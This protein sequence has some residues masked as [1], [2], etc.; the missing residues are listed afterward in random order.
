[1]NKKTLLNTTGLALFIPLAF[2]QCKKELSPPSAQQS[3]KQ[4]WIKDYFKELSS[5]NYPNIYAVSW[6]Q[7][8]FD[9]SFLS[10]NSSEAALQQY[11][12][13]VSNS[14]FLEQCLFVNGKLTFQAN[15]IYH[16]A[17]PNFGGTED[18]VSDSSIANFEVLAKKKIAWAYFSNNWVRGISFPQREVDIIKNAGK[19]PFIRMMSRSQFEANKADPQWRLI[20]IIHGQFDT[21]LKAWARAAKNCGTNLLVEFGAEVNGSWFP[22]NGSYNGGATLNGYGD[23][24]YPDG[25]EIFRD[26]FR[27]IIDLFKQEQVNNIT[28]FFHVDASGSPGEWW[29]EARYYYP[30]DNYID[31]IGVSTYGPQKKTDSYTRPKDLLDGAYKMLQSVSASKPYAVVELGATEW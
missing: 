3:N 24:N 4:Q 9:S 1:M 12:T 22:W 13:E 26:A 29:N 14:L 17:F 6:W 20:D 11:Q 10:V 27:H 8:N 15:K 28:W 21:S 23:P 16:A 30:G 2:L 31:W 18:Q 7:E 19:V 5:P 25:P